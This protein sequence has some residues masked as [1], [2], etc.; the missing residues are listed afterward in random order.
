[1]G[2]V[3]GEGGSSV[4]GGVRMKADIRCT[5]GSLEPSSWFKAPPASRARELEGRRRGGDSSLGWRVVKVE[6]SRVLR[7]RKSL[8]LLVLMPFKGIAG[9]RR[10]DSHLGG[11]DG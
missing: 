11:V 6:M 5:S 7:R 8:S 3:V 1:M 9:C 2:G 4:E 10:R